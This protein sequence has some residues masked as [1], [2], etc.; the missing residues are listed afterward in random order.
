[1]GRLRSLS[2]R[3]GDIQ[4]DDDGEVIGRLS[5]DDSDF[6]SWE[7]VVHVFMLP[8]AIFGNWVGKKPSNN[9]HRSWHAMAL[10]EVLKEPRTYYRIG[11]ISN[12][13]SESDG[14]AQRSWDF[15]FAASLQQIV[16]V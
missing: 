10:M 15:L 9:S 16:L 4:S 12:T 7:D 8:I 5:L 14:Y 3:E 6:F 1:M 11:Y 2:C 13:D